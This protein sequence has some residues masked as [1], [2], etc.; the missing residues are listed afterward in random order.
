MRCRLILPPSLIH[1]LCSDVLAAVSVRRCRR[2]VLSA[3]QSVSWGV[4]GLT[5]HSCLHTGA[6]EAEALSSTDCKFDRQPVQSNE[7]A[8]SQLLLVAD[9]RKI[10]CSLLEAQTRCCFKLVS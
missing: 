1:S 4:L 5:M 8:T 6:G 7:F 3:V 2:V 9:V 10:L